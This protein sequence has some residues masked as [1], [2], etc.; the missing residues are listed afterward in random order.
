MFQDA[1]ARFQLVAQ[2]TAKKTSILRQLS[3]SIRKGGEFSTTDDGS[4][5]FPKH[6]SA[7]ITSKTPGTGKFADLSRKVMDYDK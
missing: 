5:D 3:N 4:Q 6:E 2:K 7:L 1:K